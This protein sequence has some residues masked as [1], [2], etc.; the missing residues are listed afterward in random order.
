V[1][2]LELYIPPRRPGEI[3][4][5]RRAEKPPLCQ[6]NMALLKL[7]NSPIQNCGIFE[8]EIGEKCLTK[9]NKRLHL[10]KN[11]I[12]ALTF[13]IAGIQYSEL[14]KE[15]QPFRARCCMV[16]IR[17]QKVRCLRSAA[18]V[19]DASIVR[20]A[21]NNSIHFIRFCIWLVQ[22]KPRFWFYCVIVL[23]I[24]FLLLHTLPIQIA[25]LHYTLFRRFCDHVLSR[26]N[27]IWSK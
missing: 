24:H 21:E 22:A 4:S 13:K 14:V 26:K 19:A 18:S 20:N 12:S 7:G 10:C 11:I 23:L 8:A 25:Y 27:Q 1:V 16:C 5:G 17:P 9:H 2:I 15:I 3:I 6:V